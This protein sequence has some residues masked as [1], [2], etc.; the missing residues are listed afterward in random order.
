MIDNMIIRIAICFSYTY[1]DLKTTEYTESNKNKT[2]L[3]VT[4][5]L[6]TLQCS[7]S[8]ELILNSSCSHHTYRTLESCHLELGTKKKVPNCMSR[9]KFWCIFRGISFVH[10]RLKESFFLSRPAKNTCRSCCILFV[11]KLFLRR[12]KIYSL[13]EYL[14]KNASVHVTDENIVSLHMSRF[15]ATAQ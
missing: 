7:L 6:S 9:I 12:R 11:S 3:R 13:L 14:V 1:T 5:A 15:S 8:P 10:D 2:T 4:V